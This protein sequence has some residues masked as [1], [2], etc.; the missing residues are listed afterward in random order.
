MKK[1]IF[2]AVFLYFFMVFSLTFAFAAG[3]SQSTGLLPSNPFYFVK[4]WT[5]SVKRAWIFDTIKKIE[6]DLGIV[7]EKAAELQKIARIAPEKADLITNAVEN[8]Q[9]NLEQLI[10][11]VESLKGLN[12]SDINK[13]LDNLVE[14]SLVHAELLSS[15]SSQFNQDADLSV[16]LKDA[17]KRVLYIMSIIPQKVERPEDFRIRLQQIINDQSQ[18]FKEFKAAEI[19]DYLELLLPSGQLRNEINKLKKDLLLKFG[20]QVQNGLDQEVFSQ[21]VM[22]PMI[23]LK[24]LDEIRK[25]VSDQDLKNKLNL[26]RQRALDQV[27]Q[28]GKIGNLEAQVAL[29]QATQS[30]SLLQSKVRSGQAFDQ[31]KFY[32]TQAQNFYGQTNYVSAFS[33]AVSSI[34]VSDEALRQLANKELA[35][36]DQK[37]R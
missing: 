21:L 28:S 26:L 29:E 8:Y 10:P 24:L 37:N 6:Y 3:V 2:Y 4:E 35:L 18:D 13:L 11:Q 20:V 31:A 7:D 25:S 32:L 15:L 34:G 22:D 9:L 27:S 14:K 5:R 30:L 16:K 36:S 23:Q 1:V 12:I 33:Q 19:L 17:E